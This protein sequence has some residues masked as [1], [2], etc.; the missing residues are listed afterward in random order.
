ME[1]LNID[2][3]GLSLVDVCRLYPEQVAAAIERHAKGMAPG[4]RV[5][6]FNGQILIALKVFQHW[7]QNHRGSSYNVAEYETW[8]RQQQETKPCCPILEKGF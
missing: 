3:R 4:D 6:E 2:P 8:L 5:T 7:W 1:G